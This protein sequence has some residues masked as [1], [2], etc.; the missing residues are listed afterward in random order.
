MKKT[1]DYD[2]VREAIKQ[3]SE[4]SI[5]YLGCDSQ[6][7][8][9]F[10][11][12]GLS[13]IIHIDGHK[14]GKLFVETTKVKRIQ[15]LKQRLLKEVE[16]AVAGAFEI[17]ESI[18]DRKFEVHLD[19]N[20][21]PEHKSNVVCKEAIGYVVGQGFECQIKPYAFAASYA[22]DHCVKNKLIM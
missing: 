8:K 2:E 18:G 1:I 16:L 20:G 19:I 21:N 9:G 17:M 15:S 12:F 13:I 22:S 5:I 11:I 6:N 7:S 10:T 14:G 4:S 3:S